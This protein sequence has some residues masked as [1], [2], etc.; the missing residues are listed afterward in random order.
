MGIVMQ[1]GQPYLPHRP[2]LAGRYFSPVT[3]TAT[4]QEPTAFR[5]RRYEVPPGATDLLLVRHGASEAYLD[6]TLFPLVDGH[7][8]PPLSAEGRQQAGLVCKR[9]AVAGVDAIYVSNLRRTAETAAPLAAQ[10]G[11][12]LRVEADLREVYLGEWEGGIF[13]KMVAEGHPISLRMAAEERWDVIPGAEP[14]AELEG[15]V[16]SAIERLAAA[17]PGQRVAAFTHGGVIGQAIALASASRPFAFLGAENSSISRIVVTSDRWIVR[18]FN[19]TAHLD[20]D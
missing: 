14:A 9:L 5:Q 17:H 8:D 6:G 15:R 10:L 16:R 3:D 13:R 19:D 18:G 11:L 7:G 4:D 20:G 12:D 2:L 1:H